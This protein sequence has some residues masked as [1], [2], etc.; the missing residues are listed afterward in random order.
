VQRFASSFS[1]FEGGVAMDDLDYHHLVAQLTRHEGFRLRHYQDV[2][3]NLSV[4]RGA[5]HPQRRT[6][7]TVE[8][9]TAL[10]SDL[11]R[12]A[13]ELERQL[14][15]FGKL[16]AVRQRV[17]LH[18]AFN[19]GVGHLLTMRK[20]IAAVG[21]RHWPV[22]ADE[23][24]LSSWSAEDKARARVLAEMMRTGRDEQ[25]GR[26]SRDWENDCSPNDTAHPGRRKRR[27]PT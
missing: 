12:I 7:T 6:V 22:A 18:I 13:C 16:D 26:V 25:S 24:L 27:R 2:G 19:V 20:L 10:E 23:M 15:A 5:R 8:T 1:R 9:T 17:L 14:P 3:G 4:S 21:V 11:R